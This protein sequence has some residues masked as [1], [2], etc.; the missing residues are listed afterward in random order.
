MTSQCRISLAEKKGLLL[1][2]IDAEDADEGDSHK[3]AAT[4]GAGCNN[5]NLRRSNCIVTAHRALSC[6]GYQLFPDVRL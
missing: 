3:L 4:N 2:Q 6:Q 1:I 5:P